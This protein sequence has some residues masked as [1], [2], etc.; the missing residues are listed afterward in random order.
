MKSIIYI[1]LDDTD[2]LGEPPGTGRVARD[3]ALHLESLGLGKSVGVSRHQLLVDPRIPYTSHNS[4]LCIG[5]ET[6]AD[7]KLFVTPCMEYVQQHSKNG[8]DPGLCLLAASDAKKELVEFG[9]RA[10][11]EVLTKKEAADLAA[12][13]KIVLK[14]LG[15]S[16]G[17]IIGALSAC[18]LRADGN[19]GRF[20][21]LRGIRQITG[22]VSAGELKSRTAIEAVY[23]PGGELLDD[24]QRI[25]SYSWIRPS[26][27]G[28]KIVLRVQPV[29]S[30]EG[31]FFW[32]PVENRKDKPKKKQEAC[33]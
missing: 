17:G 20:V 5:M 33:E 32:E 1:G 2:I 8:S 16:G 23:T 29:V 6:P 18:V 26:L 27:Q 28:G 22:L 24:G 21:E 3:L 4:S 13:H 19:H 12:K 25:E 14:E 11:S 9:G 31:P 10:T 7:L 15:G 30:T